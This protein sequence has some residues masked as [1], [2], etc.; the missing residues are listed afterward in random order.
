MQR[1]F[2]GSRRAESGD[3][4]RTRGIQAF[5]FFL[6]DL[7]GAVFGAVVDDDDFVRDAAEVQLEMEMLDGRC[8]AAFLVTRGNDDRQESEWGIF[9]RR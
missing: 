8:D 7:P 1:C 2:G 5:G 4:R 3:W 6:E 9:N